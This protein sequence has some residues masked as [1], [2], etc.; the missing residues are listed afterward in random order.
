MDH[1]EPNTNDPYSINGE[2][3]LNGPVIE[4]GF[5]ENGMPRGRPTLH[6]HVSL[7]ILI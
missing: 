1:P 6:P 2:M 4:V 5:V 7:P 3:L